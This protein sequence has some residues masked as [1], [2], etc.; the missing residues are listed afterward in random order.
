MRL[1]LTNHLIQGAFLMKDQLPVVG[2]SAWTA[3][4]IA[5]QLAVVV[6]ADIFLT[7]EVQNL[8]GDSPRLTLRTVHNLESIVVSVRPVADARAQLAQLTGDR[9]LEGYEIWAVRQ[10]ALTDLL[11]TSSLTEQP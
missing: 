1:L 10:R 3:Q 11:I 7:D 2:N 6:W 8:S 4:Q 9:L 5:D